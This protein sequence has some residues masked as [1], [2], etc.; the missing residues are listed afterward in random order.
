MTKN[1]KEVQKGV[2]KPKPYIY[3]FFVPL[4]RFLFRIFFNVKRR[5]TPEAKALKK[6]KEPM[7]VIGTHTSA[8]DFMLMLTALMPKR[9]NVVCGR[10]LLAWKAVRPVAKGAGIIPISQ[11]DM[12]LQSLREMKYAIKN[13]CSL[14]IFPEGK[15]SVDGRPLHHM[16]KS[17][18]K[19]LKFL[20]V[21][22]V[23]VHNNGGYS[24]RPRWFNGIKKGKIE[25]EVYQLFTKE[26]VHN[27]SKDE[28]YARLVEAFD[29]ND[30]IYQQENGIRYRSWA[31]AKNL[32]FLLYKC[33]RCGAEYEMTTSKNNITCNKCG[34]DVRFSEFGRFIPDEKSFAFD[35]IDTWYNYQRESVREEIK[36]PDFR[37]SKQVTWAKQLTPISEKVPAGEGEL[38]I[39]NTNIG[40]IGKT[41][42]GEEVCMTIPLKLYATIV[43]KTDEGIDLTLDSCINRFMFVEGKYSTKYNLIVEE[44]FRRL[45]N[46]PPVKKD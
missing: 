39:D 35:R 29:F 43:Q 46:L 32:Q 9:L 31:P 44:Q 13:G 19:L 30:N 14:S 27:L 28:L 8:M 24:S 15:I 38:Y 22:V 40:F 41:N 7:V 18:P 26:E 36:N 10:D 33:P 25:T 1:T 4:G 37:I 16:S 12:D 34:N 21:P 11:F 23:M 3:W 20:D 6:S 5:Y 17:I 42:N 45:N 2:K